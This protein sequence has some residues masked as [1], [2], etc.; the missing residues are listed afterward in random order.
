MKNRFFFFRNRQEK[1][2][3]ITDRIIYVIG[4]LSI[5]TNETHALHNKGKKQ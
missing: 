2:D 5:E 1:P 4:V 3:L